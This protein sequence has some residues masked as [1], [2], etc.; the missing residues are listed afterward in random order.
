[1]KK[2]I[3]RV[4]IILIVIG[5]IVVLFFV[6]KALIIR[7]VNYEIAGVKIPAEYNMITG[8]VRPILNYTGKP[9]SQTIQSQRVREIDL[10]R[11]QIAMA[12]LRWALFEEWTK[13]RP[14]YKNWESDPELFKKANE[15]FKKEFEAHGPRF[16]MVE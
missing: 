15:E 5:I 6:Y 3:R 12:Q 10:P 11:E 8:K 13:A 2:I 16:K 9:L 4:E 7:M 1:M 14:Q